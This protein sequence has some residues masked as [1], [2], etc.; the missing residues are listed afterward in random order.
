MH[1]A[2]TRVGGQNDINYTDSNSPFVAF[3]VRQRNSFF[4]KDI[5]FG[6]SFGDYKGM[7]G[8]LRKHR[9]DVANLPGAAETIHVDLLGIRGREG[10]HTDCAGWSDIAE[11][12]FFLLVA[13]RRLLTGSRGGVRECSARAMEAGGGK[14]PGGGNWLSILSFSVVVVLRRHELDGVLVLRHLKLDLSEHGTRRLLS[15]HNKERGGVI[16]EASLAPQF[17]DLGVHGQE[18]LVEGISAVS[19]GLGNRLGA[20]HTIVV[21]GVDHF[22]TD[23]KQAQRR[24]PIHH[25]EDKTVGLGLGDMS[26]DKTSLFR[27]CVEDIA[28]NLGAQ[29]GLYA[30]SLRDAGHNDLEA[31]FDLDLAAAHHGDQVWGDR[32]DG[33]GSCRQNVVDMAMVGER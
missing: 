31:V 22:V 3:A 19:E 4:L 25:I 24:R 13:L 18:S 26:V 32:G 23:G 15:S 16:R 30:F 5:V 21:V 29:S 6:R 27:D 8:S 11:S 1:E 33:D 10:E 28:L 20:S 17:S 7:W 9:V 14:I 12:S 2:M